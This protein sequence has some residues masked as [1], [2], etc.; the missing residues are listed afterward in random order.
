MYWRLLQIMQDWCAIAEIKILFFLPAAP[1]K[2]NSGKFS[3][4][5]N[6]SL[7]TLLP[8]GNRLHQKDLPGQLSWQLRVPSGSLPFTTT[9]TFFMKSCVAWSSSSV[10]C[11]IWMITEGS[12]CFISSR[13]LMWRLRRWTMYRSSGSPR[14]GLVREQKQ[15][16]I[17]KPTLLKQVDPL[18]WQSFERSYFRW[19]TGVKLKSFHLNN[20]QE[21]M[22]VIPESLEIATWL[23]KFQR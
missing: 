17:T 18:R 8:S 20:E 1:R 14:N 3:G 10:V 23:P 16:P 19:F 15:T 7:T 13:D 6:N 12:S 21:G 4:N 22:P 5:L 11:L 9:S 2:W